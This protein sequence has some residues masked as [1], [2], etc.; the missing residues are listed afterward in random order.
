MGGNLGGGEEA[1]GTQ[2]SR[3][4][5][6]SL[7]YDKSGARLAW[8]YERI[9]KATTMSSNFYQSGTSNIVTGGYTFGAFY[10]AGLVE[11]DT[12][13]NINLTGNDRTRDYWHILGKFTMGKHA[14]GAWYGKAAAW[15]GAAG[16]PDSGAKMWT[17]GYSYAI[18]PQAGLYAL[19]T[20][21]DNDSRA[22]YVLGGSP[23]RGAGATGDWV[24]SRATQPGVVFG[25]F[26][27]FQFRAERQEGAGL[28]AASSPT[29]LPFSLRGL[30][31]PR[32]SEPEMRFLF[33]PGARLMLRMPNEKKLPLMTGLFLLPLA[34][35]LYDVGGGA[36]NT[37]LLWVA[38]GVVVALYAM[39]SFYVQADMGWRILIA[40]MERI[41][42]GDLTTRIDA[43]LGGHFG[44]V[45]RMLEQINASLGKIVRQ[46]R[47]SSQAVAVSAREI[48]LASANLSQRTERQATTLEETASA[49]EEFSASVRHNAGN[50]ELASE[51]ARGADATA[52]EGARVVHG[53]VQAM[54]LMQ[55]GSR[56]IA[57]IVGVIEG[58]AFQTN[59]LAL[60]AAVEAA[61]AGEQ[62]RGFAVVAAEVRA[63]AQRSADAAKEV[64]TLI[65]SSVE[66]VEDGTRKA[67][68]A[69]RA[70][71]A[72]VEAV[73]QGNGLIGEIASASAQQ[74]SSVQEISRAIAQLEDVTQQNSAMV[75]EA[76]AKSM[77]FEEEAN[78]LM[79]IVKSFRIDAEPAAATAGTIA[80]ATLLPRPSGAVPR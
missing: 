33:V 9:T 51:K 28:G 8:G 19:Y 67:G 46:V 57:E 78:R 25:G 11:R 27:N 17:A 73:R 42:Q 59:I 69:G 22:G 35:L 55:A 75:E 72:I 48:A 15:K 5:S 40:S 76:A 71:D 79:V 74:S 44:L 52:H 24:P 16:I 36:S 68:E 32:A 20:R 6:A 39:G 18:A 31:D 7:A 54:S 62:G 60:N 38:A 45:M 26:I 14:I 1:L 70:I 49:M 65:Q 63:L 37:T 77:A 41:S 4:L 13:E 56:R 80:R 29:R 21:L 50:C 47:S 2:G 53:V 12:L 3:A 64:R 34:L 23:A 30:R 58:I 43:K 66:Q 10:I 61:R